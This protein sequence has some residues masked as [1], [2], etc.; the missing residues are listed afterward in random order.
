MESAAFSAIMMVGA[1]LF[2][3]M[4]VGIRRFQK[5]PGGFKAAPR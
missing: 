4:S 2:P 5:K 1:V 3:L